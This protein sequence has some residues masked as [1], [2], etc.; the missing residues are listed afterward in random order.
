MTLVWGFGLLAQ[1]ALACLLVFA[2]PIAD[3][4]IVSP[5]LGYGTMGALGLWTFWYGRASG[6]KARPDGPRRPSRLRPRRERPDAARPPPSRVTDP[7]AR[8]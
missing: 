7:G 3:Y 5:I 2:L 8:P 6:A 1:T 4:L